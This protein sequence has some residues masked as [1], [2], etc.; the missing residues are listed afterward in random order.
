MIWKRKGGN[1]LIISPLELQKNSAT[2]TS[3][4]LSWVMLIAYQGLWIFTLH[5]WNL[6]Y[7]THW[8]GNHPFKRKWGGHLPS[9]GPFTKSSAP[10]FSISW[11]KNLEKNFLIFSMVEPILVM[12]WHPL[13]IPPPLISRRIHKESS[14]L[15]ERSTTDMKWDKAHFILIREIASPSSPLFNAN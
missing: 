1:L 14:K 4:D 5:I 8:E 13:S 3:W 15:E 7:S 6:W 11:S 2:S 9:N 10:G 12:I